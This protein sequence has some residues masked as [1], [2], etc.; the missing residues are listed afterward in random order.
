MSDVLKRSL[1]QLIKELAKL[2]HG[3]FLSHTDFRYCRFI[4]SYLQKSN[5]PLI[6]KRGDIHKLRIVWWGHRKILTKIQWCSKT[7][8]FTGGV[9]G[10]G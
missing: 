4:T 1:K 2:A 3:Y 8:L 5:L 6:I 9:G 10:V 7:S